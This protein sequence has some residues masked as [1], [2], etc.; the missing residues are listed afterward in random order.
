MTVDL[1][2]LRQRPAAD[3]GAEPA[4]RRGPAFV[5]GLVVFLGAL[6]WAALLM[7]DVILPPKSVRT[8]PIRVES[9]GPGRRA[10]AFDATG[11][12]E[13]DPFP[14]VVRPLV[15]GVVEKFDVVEGTVVK[16]G[17]TVLA[18]LRN[19]QLEAAVESAEKA[20]AHT[21]AHLPE[22]DADVV[23]A[24]RLLETK[25]ALRADVA[26][27]EGEARTAEAEKAAAEA[28]VAVAQSEK[29]AAQIELSAQ[30]TLEAG[31]SGVRVAKAKASVAVATAEAMLGQKRA[32]V[33]KA[34]AS[35]ASARAQLTVARDA[36]EHPITLEAALARVEAHRKAADADAAEGETT[37]AIARRYVDLLVVRSP[38]DGVVLR[39]KAAPGSAVGPGM[40]P[41]G[42]SDGSEGS[43]GDLVALYDPSR[44]Q[45]RTNVP[46]ASVGSVGVGQAAEL[47]LDALPGRTFHGEVVRL[48]S[49][50]DR[51][52][53][54]LEAKVRVKDP[55]PV[56]KPE[57]VVR[58]RFLVPEGPADPKSS[59]VRIVVPKAA[60]H[61][62]SV[63]VFDPRSGGRARRVPVTKVSENGDGVEVV[64]ELSATQQVILDT[65]EDG[66]RVT[67]GGSGGSS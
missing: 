44:L 46:L 14:I 25:F 37:L 61:G 27:L 31:G 52:N 66:Q 17:E 38:A 54:T 4:S 24:R 41:G 2:V 8:A 29:D 57:M 22:V 20:L 7:K 9:G 55:D 63:F 10:S 23:E 33:A 65:V 42:G 47:T 26:R 56:M 51:A 40:R 16:A 13:P 21:R 48:V 62:D 1:E 64:G 11:W 67:D 18:R 5:V 53:N 3:A 50:A 34:E 43:E 60:V 28:E 45:V 59:S 32:A 35:A 49:Q 19:P 36:L 30:E 6:G 39:R 15:D 12:V 58:V